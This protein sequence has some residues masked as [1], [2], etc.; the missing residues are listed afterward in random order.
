MEAVFNDEYY[1]ED[2]GQYPYGADDE[3][4]NDM[5]YDY[6]EGGDEGENAGEI[7]EGE[8]KSKDKKKDKKGKQ[9][10]SGALLLW[11]HSSL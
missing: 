9:Q 1:N 3:E 6:D 5:N 4:L 2:D 11:V 8:R 7:I 10:V